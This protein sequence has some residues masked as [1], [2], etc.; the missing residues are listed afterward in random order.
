MNLVGESLLFLII[1]VI[2]C[3]YGYVWKLTT[4]F[5]VAWTSKVTERILTWS[6]FLFIGF[7]TVCF[8]LFQVVLLLF[9]YFAIFHGIAL[10]FLLAL[11]WN[12]WEQWKDTLV[13]FLFFVFPL[14]RNKKNNSCFLENYVSLVLRCS[15][16]RV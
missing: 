12:W 2:R 8:K 9:I 6:T 5:N 13:F 7:V 3:M 1:L 11:I 14:N 16:C 10:C 4:I 15:G